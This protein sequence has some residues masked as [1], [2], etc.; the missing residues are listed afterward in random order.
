M[1]N[2][3]T[4]NLVI[5]MTLFAVLIVAGSYTLTLMSGKQS[6]VQNTV[7]A[8]PTPYIPQSNESAKNQP[9]KEVVMPKPPVFSGKQVVTLT[10]DGFAPSSITIKTGTL[11]QWINKSGQDASVNSDDHP[12]HK[13]YPSLNLGIFPNESGVSLIFDKSGTYKYHDH[14]HPERNGTIIVE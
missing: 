3:S 12:T 9:A 7:S 13:L 14:L 4:K 5:G 10:K 1:Q 2:I 8:S 11:I 6:N